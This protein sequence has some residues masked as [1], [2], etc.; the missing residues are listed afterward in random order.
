M[1]VWGILALYLMAGLQLSGL[2]SGF[3]WKSLVDQLMTVERAPITR[4]EKEQV[5]NSSRTK[6]LSDLGAKITALQTAATALKDETIFSGRLAKSTTSDSTWSIASSP[7]SAPGRYKI[8]VA[9]LATAT[10]RDGASDIGQGLNTTNDVSGLTLATL[11]TG[12]APTAGTFTI[13]G[14]KVTV[15]L[16]DSLADVFDKISDATG[17]DVTA[18]YDAATDKITLTSASESVIT[19]GAAND[20]SNLLRALKLGNNGSDVV[21]SSGLLGAIKTTA[22]LNAAGLRTAVTN[23]DSNGAGTFSI[24]GV[25]IAFDVDGDTL[26]GLIKRINQSG[27]GVTASYDSVNDRMQLINNSTGDLGVSVSETSGGLL[28]ALGLTTGATTARGDNAEFRIN[29]GATLTATGNTLDAST[30]GIEGLTVTVDSETTQ[31]IAISADTSSMRKKVDAFIEA[32][33]AVQTFIDEKS[34]V[35]SANGKV[36]TSVLSS[37][38]EVQEWARDLRSVAFSAVS[39]L[40]GTI[41]R[42]ENLGIDFDGTTGKLAI[43]DDAKLTAALTNK[44]EDVEAFFQTGSTGFVAKLTKLLDRMESSNDDQQERITKNNSDIDRQ[45]GDLERRLEQQ[46]ELLTSGFIKMEEAQARIQQQGNALT[47]AFF[48]SS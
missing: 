41:Q 21:E 33:N 34:K 13:N 42:L 28:A 23:T 44:P 26:A 18:A 16:T 48:K 8:A 27:A 22:K 10:R 38:R 40:T 45:I 36:T 11:A 4:L 43:D 37:N 46:R 9:Q 39:G 35:T 32:F 20:T 19:L 7:G 1:K 3:D 14:A 47:N 17:D 2:A 5:T 25:E 29:D 15:A 24:N 30:H 12:V 31:T 6:A